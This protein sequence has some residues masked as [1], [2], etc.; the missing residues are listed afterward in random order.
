MHSFATGTTDF[1]KLLDQR[2]SYRRTRR[3]RLWHRE[4]RFNNRGRDNGW[5]APGIQHKLNSHINFIDRIKSILPI[6]KT[7]V[8][9]ASFDQQKMQ[10][11]YPLQKVW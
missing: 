8:E 4:P 5:F 6:T 10:N 3:G 1:M 2:A 11:P 7:V 9:I